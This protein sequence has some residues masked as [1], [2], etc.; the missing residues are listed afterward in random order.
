MTSEEKSDIL[1]KKINHVVGLT[2]QLIQNIQNDINKLE[3]HIEEMHCHDKQSNM[4]MYEYMMETYHDQ[5]KKKKTD[6][7]NFE[8][9]MELLQ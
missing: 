9:I 5:I 3:L 6:K 8:M 2:A 4:P 1:Q 7:R